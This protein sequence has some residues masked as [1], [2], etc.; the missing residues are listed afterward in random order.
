MRTVD[1]DSMEVLCTCARSPRVWENGWGG[2]RLEVQQQHEKMKRQ[3]ETW[4]RNM[5]LSNETHARMHKFPEHVPRACDSEARSAP[6]DALYLVAL[7]KKRRTARVTDI[8]VREWCTRRSR[9]ARSTLARD[10]QTTSVQGSSACV[11]TDRAEGREERIRKP[12]GTWSADSEGKKGRYGV[13]TCKV[14]SFERALHCSSDTIWALHDSPGTITR[15]PAN[16]AVR[17]VRALLPFSAAGVAAA[18]PVL[19]LVWGR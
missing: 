12:A 9:R 16:H 7:Q 15:V 10:V 18:L 8:Y 19:L 3:A 13:Q 1:T 17:R 4:S 14:L 2:R 11:G 6:L 5:T